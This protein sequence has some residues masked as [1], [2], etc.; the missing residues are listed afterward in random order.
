MGRPVS[1]G[2][3]EVS[4]FEERARYMLDV[5]PKALADIDA[6]PKPGFRRFIRREPVG[7]VF[8]I[9]PWNFPYM[10]VVNAVWPA[11][12]AG[13][14]VVLKHAQQTALAGERMMRALAGAGLPA[15]LFQALPMTHATAAAVM[16]SEPVR[17]VTFTGSVR[18]GRAV[19]TAVADAANFPATGLELSGKDP[20]YVRADADLDHAAH[21]RH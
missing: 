1:Q 3:G 11:L 17:L 16:Q 18:G 9:A 10:T 19:R 20:A 14:A 13:N 12:A 21:C 15:D 5:A 4:G 7:V 8:T 6:G 2:G